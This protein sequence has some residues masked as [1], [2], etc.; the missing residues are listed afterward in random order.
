LCVIEKKTEYKKY[1]LAIF[2]EVEEKVCPL[3][4]NRGEPQARCCIERGSMKT[5][6]FQDEFTENLK[7]ITHTVE[8]KESIKNIIKLCARRKKRKKIREK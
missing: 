4:G 6:R 7:K 5:H 2:F 3:E 8:Q 1:C